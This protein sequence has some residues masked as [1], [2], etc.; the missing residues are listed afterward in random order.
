M[1]PFSTFSIKF[2]YVIVKIGFKI[3]IYVEITWIPMV[4]PPYVPLNY[5]ED[6]IMLE[7]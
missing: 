5:E 4:S 2:S 7:K 3:N 1:I 6:E